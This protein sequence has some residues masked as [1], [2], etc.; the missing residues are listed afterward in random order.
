MFPLI[1]KYVFEE[2]EN[3][4]LSKFFTEEWIYDELIE[5]SIELMMA[6]FKTDVKPFL[7]SPIHF[8]KIVKLGF[9]HFIEI[10]F[11]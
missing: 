9:E 3:Q 10:Y 6:Y 4:L 8:N 11:D 5:K 1:L 7:L 2:I